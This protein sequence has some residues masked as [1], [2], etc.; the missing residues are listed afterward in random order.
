MGTAVAEVSTLEVKSYGMLCALDDTGDT[1]LQWDPDNVEEV[2]KAQSRFNDLKTK[3]YLAYSVN[4]KGDQGVVMKDF[5]PKAERIIM[6]SQMVG[7]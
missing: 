3:G 1:R 4:A 5:D 7:G 2:A 6:H